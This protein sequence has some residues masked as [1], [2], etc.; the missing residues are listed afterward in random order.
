MGLADWNIQ[1]GGSLVLHDAILHTTVPDQQL[2][3]D[4]W[5]RRLYRNT[6]DGDHGRLLFRYIRETFSLTQDLSVRLAVAME[7][8]NTAGSISVGV[9]ARMDSTVTAGT[10]SKPKRLTDNGYFLMWTDDTDQYVITLNR[11]TSGVETEL[12]ST[13]VEGALGVTKWWQIRMDVLMQANGD[14]I[15]QLWENDPSKVPVDRAAWTR[16]GDDIT[17]SAP[18]VPQF[19]G[20]GWGAQTNDNVLEPVVVDWAEI[21]RS[22]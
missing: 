15:I 4:D 13:T 19:S 9:G 2:T 18:L 6:V 16:L 3:H 17:E 12:F 10:T 22:A 8:Q 1:N 11:V 21:H 14:A 20:A 5:A 7:V